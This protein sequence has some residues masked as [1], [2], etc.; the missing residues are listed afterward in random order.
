M[1]IFRFVCVALLA[2]FPI[3]SWAQAPAKPLRIEVTEGVFE[4]M[5]IAISPFLSSGPTAEMAAK[6]QP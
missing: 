5:P 1:T 3:K 4:P 6:I 2:T